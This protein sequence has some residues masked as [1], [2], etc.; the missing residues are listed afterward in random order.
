MKISVY[1]VLA[2]L[3]FILMSALSTDVSAQVQRETY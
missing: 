1:Q 2:I 3:S